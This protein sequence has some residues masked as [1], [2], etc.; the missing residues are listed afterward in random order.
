MSMPYMPVFVST[1]ERSAEAGAGAAG[2]ALGSHTWRGKAPA[3]APKPTSMKNTAAYVLRGV[4][5]LFAANMQSPIS[6]DMPPI[7]D[8]V[9]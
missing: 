8:T 3:F 9:R 6:I 1:P 2:C 4:F 7:T 5:A